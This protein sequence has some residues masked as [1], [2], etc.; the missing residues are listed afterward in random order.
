MNYKIKSIITY[1]KQCFLRLS[2]VTKEPQLLAQ[3]IPIQSGF[4][5]DKGKVKIKV[6][7]ESARSE[8]G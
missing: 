5:F 1:I 7:F 4:R 2:K 3:F 8:V 6:K